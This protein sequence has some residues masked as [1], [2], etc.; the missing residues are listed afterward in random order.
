MSMPRCSRPPAC[1][2]PR[3]VADH[4]DIGAERH[5]WRF[6][7][8]TGVLTPMTG[9]SVGRATS[10]LSGC[11]VPLAL[12]TKLIVWPIGLVL[13]LILE[14]SG[15]SGPRH[16]CS[17]RPPPRAGGRWFV[18]NEYLYGDLTG[19]RG[20][21]EAGYHFPPLGHIDPIGLVRSVMTDPGHPPSTSVT[22][23]TR[24]PGW[25]CRRRRSPPPARSALCVSLF[26]CG[27]VAPWSRSWRLP[28]SPWRPARDGHC[29]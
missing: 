21:T 3:H 26:G 11:L 12:I 4:G 15:G 28:C 14:D 2:S 17:R 20:V 19:R 13:G 6:C 18:R 10:A 27:P 24:Q 1:C 16:S 5:P 7:S 8:A 22:S 9:E 29:A 23:S 25:T